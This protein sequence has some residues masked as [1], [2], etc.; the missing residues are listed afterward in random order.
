MI[1]FLLYSLTFIV[2]ILSLLCVFWTIYAAIKYGNKPITEIPTWAI[3]FMY[4]K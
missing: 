1:K 2:I 4:R 3:W